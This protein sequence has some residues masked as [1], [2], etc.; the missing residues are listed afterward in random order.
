MQTWTRTIS[1]YTFTIT[2]HSFSYLTAV[3]T[4][5]P[6]HRSFT[7][8]SSI[9]KC[10][11]EAVEGQSSILDHKSVAF[12]NGSRS[13]PGFGSE[14]CCK[15][16]V[17]GGGV[18]TKNKCGINVIVYFEISSVCVRPYPPFPLTRCK[19]RYTEGV[20]ALL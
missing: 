3:L 2:Q 20:L 1:K 12:I 5:K 8:L 16:N 11:G 13:T 18:G 19:I 6:C 9:Y 10:R 4:S 17:T 7:L 15:N 14:Y